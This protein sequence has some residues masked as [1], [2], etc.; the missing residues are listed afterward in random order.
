MLNQL[1]PLVVVLFFAT[2]VFWLVKPVALR[3]MEETDFVRRRNVWFALTVSAF[4]SPSFWF[5]LLFAAPLLGWAASKDK[6]PMAL[7]LFMLHVIPPISIELPAVAINRLFELDNYRLLGFL[8]LLPAAVRI[9]S[10][11]QTPSVAFRFSDVALIAYIVLSL[12]LLI[13][14]ESLT[15]TMRRAFLL[16]LDVGLVYYVFSRSSVRRDKLVESLACFVLTLSVMS[17]IAMFEATRDWLMYTGINDRWGD[18]NVFAWLLRE[19]ALRA[20]SSAGHSLALGYM[21]AM[22]LGMWLYLQRGV[23]D[24]YRRWSIIAILLGGAFATI[25]RGPWLVAVLAYLSYCALGPLTAGQIGKRFALFGVAGLAVLASPWGNSLVAY[26]PFVGTVDEGNVTYRQELAILSWQLIK[27]NPFFGSPFVLTQMESMRQGQ[28]IID[29]VNVYA[30][31]A[32]LYGCIG[33]F[34]FLAPFLRGLG[35]LIVLTRARHAKHGSEVSVLAAS[36]AACMFGS[37]LMLA[38]GSFGSSTA[39]LFWVFT[40]IASGV[41]VVRL[42]TTMPK[43]TLAEW[44]KPGLA[45]RA[46]VPLG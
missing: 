26:I 24:K 28:G 44:R 3:F 9:A 1:K 15:N 5:Y 21:C 10:E 33:L 25:S 43:P 16:L 38:V 27:Q 40:A 12:V 23:E 36:V 45:R 19:G 6:N 20:Q 18:P 31:I 13:P 30:T 22:A 34:L 29:L 8:V 11:R 42:E 32:M 2:V 4:V 46:R 14:Y 35:R 39:Y 37:L 17:S 7:T 41:A